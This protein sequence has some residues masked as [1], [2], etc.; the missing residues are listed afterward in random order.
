MDESKR[1]EYQKREYSVRRQTKHRIPLE[2][3]IETYEALK[4]KTDQDGTTITALLTNFINEYL[5]K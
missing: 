3:K 1:K 5:S 2:L 4:K